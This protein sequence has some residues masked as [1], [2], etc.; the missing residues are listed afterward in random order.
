MRRT[1][2]VWKALRA[3]LALTLLA[4]GATACG[5]GTERTSSSPARVASARHGSSSRLYP[6]HA[7]GDYDTDDYEARGDADDDDSVGRL[8]RDGDIDGEDGT[9]SETETHGFSDSDDFDLSE[10]RHSASVVEARAV[11][12]LVRRYLSAAAAADGRQACSMVLPNIARAVTPTLAGV[13][14]PP[15]SKGKTCAE[16]LSKIFRFYHAQLAAEAHV[17][18]VAKLR[19]EGEKGLAVLTAR[20]VTA[21]PIRV[22]AVQRY[23]AAWKIDGVLDQ[24]Q[25]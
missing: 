25:P 12:T 23:G 19:T 21:F 9:E 22:M 16:V 3:L 24:E 2:I 15:Y 17:L 18:R 7:V 1:R 13:G 20:P 8:D 14:E 11:A 4:L 10:Y 6:R 5:G